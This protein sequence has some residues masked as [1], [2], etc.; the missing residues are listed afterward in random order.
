MAVEIEGDLLP[1][2]ARI[3][4]ILSRFNDFITAHLLE[5]AVDVYKRHGGEEKNLTIIRVPGSFEIPVVAKRAAEGGKF[6]AVLC[7]GCVIRG[8][9]DHYDYVA[10]QAAQGIGKVAVETGVPV[11]FG[12]ITADT[13]DQAIERA[14]TKQGN[15]GA[16]AMLSAIEMA[17]LFKKMGG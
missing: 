16:K 2:N 5:G 11:I 1:R 14:G 4:V 15:H 7:L 10:V 9:T 13:L 8:A 17:N 6:E 3:A 12:V